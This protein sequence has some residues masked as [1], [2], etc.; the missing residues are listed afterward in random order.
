MPKFHSTLSRRDFMKGI[1]LIGAAASVAPSFRDIDELAASPKNSRKRAWWVKDVDHP[2]VDIDWQMMARHH[3]FHSTQSAAIVARYYGLNDYNAQTMPTTTERLKKNEP[4]YRLHDVAFAS[5]AGIWEGPLGFGFGS[6]RVTG[7]PASHK[8]YVGYQKVSTPEQMGVPKWTGSPEENSKL[9]RSAMIAYGASDV[10]FGELH[11]DHLKLVGTHGDNISTVYYPPKFP[12]PDTIIKPQVFEDVAVGYCDEKT[13]KYVLPSKVPLY[14]ITWSMPMPQEMAR[15]AHSQLMAAANTSR[16]R[17]DEHV[18]YCTLEFLRGLGYN[19]Y[20]DTNY[21]AIPTGADAVIGG[22]AENGRHSIMA[23]SPEFGAW[24]GFFHL[25]TDIPLEP[26]K[27]IDAGMWN[28]CHSCGQ[29][30]N[31]CPSNS[32]EHKGDREISYEPYPSSVTPKD[33]PLPGLGWDKTTPGE[34]DYFKTGRKTYWTDMIT[35]AGYRRTVDPC[36]RC[37]GSCVFNSPKG[38]MVHDVIRGTVANIGIF[39]GFFASMHERFGYGVVEGEAKEEWWDASL[40][41]YNINSIVGA[42]HGGYNK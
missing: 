23:L 10:A 14:M 33:P 34:T 37:F 17:R 18:T 26:T 6:W 27:P 30:A 13:G 20:S 7:G 38:A 1:G 3:G 2:T 12:P 8:A 19:G 36:L 22:L 5:A 21:R 42:Q 9:L 35:C 32:I 39:N 41:A 4:G 31:A 15:T 24:C 16:Y 28:F 25:I 11:D 29:C 40:P